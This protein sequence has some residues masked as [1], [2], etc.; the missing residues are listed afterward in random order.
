MK[1]TKV[2]IQ[3]NQP[4]IQNEIQFRQETLQVNNDE[5]GNEV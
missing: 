4:I 5:N 2:L 1:E 3:V